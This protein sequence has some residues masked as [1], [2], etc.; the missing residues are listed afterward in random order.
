MSD[1]SSKEEIERLVA[2]ASTSTF[3]NMQAPEPDLTGSKMLSVPNVSRPVT[4]IIG[5][6]FMRVCF[7]VDLLASWMHRSTAAPTSAS[8]SRLPAT[9]EEAAADV[10]NFSQS[11]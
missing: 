3:A 6:S 10:A 8:H 7:L 11:P 2:V 5:H 1:T 4:G 9:L